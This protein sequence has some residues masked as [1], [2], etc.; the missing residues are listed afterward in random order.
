[1]KGE[2]SQSKG[3]VNSYNT[4]PKYAKTSIYALVAASIYCRKSNKICWRWTFCHVTDTFIKNRFLI[5]SMQNYVSLGTYSGFKISR[6]SCE[7]HMSHVLYTQ[8]S[9]GGRQL[10]RL[11]RLGTPA[12]LCHTAVVKHHL[13]FG[14][15]QEFQSVWQQLV[16][17]NST[18]KATFWVSKC[19]SFTAVIPQL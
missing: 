15:I 19:Y 18:S 3:A 11:F 12:G 13:R 9:H 17:Q 10:C 7:K 14:G 6:Q 4:V 8:G 16:E 1:M 2:P 5:M